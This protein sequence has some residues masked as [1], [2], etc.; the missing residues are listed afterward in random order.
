M[1]EKCDENYVILTPSHASLQIYKKKG[2]HCEIIQ[3]YIYNKRKKDGRLIDNNIDKKYK[4]IIVDEIGMCGRRELNLLHKLTH[5]GRI[6]YAFGDFN[7]LQPVDPGSKFYELTDIF[8]KLLFNKLTK[9]KE[10]HRN[11]FTIEYYDKLI[12]HELDL[13]NEIKKHSE[14]NYKD[15]DAIICYYNKTVDK[16]NKMVL[17][18]KKLT[19]L[20]PGCK[21]LC[22]TNK[23]S[24]YKVYNGYTLE[25]V[26][27]NDDEQ[28]ITL[29]DACDEYTLPLKIYQKKLKN[30]E[31]F[32]PAYARTIYSLQGSSVQSYY[33]APEDIHKFNDPKTA[34][35]LISRKQTKNFT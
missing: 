35:T 4:Y 9:T 15:V 1:Y 28:T 6:I 2:L 22:K 33:A 10:N 24:I 19:M 31:F 34:Y 25:V 21:V 23:T 16:Y 27:V 32:K 13:I 5:E 17:K 14:K 12:N 20:S 26:K 7:Q 8:L 3:N 11:D 18:D 29:K 30:K